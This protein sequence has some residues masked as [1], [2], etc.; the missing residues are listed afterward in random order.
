MLLKICLFFF[1]ISNHILETK[2]AETLLS[3]IL[4]NDFLKREEGT[5]LANAF[6]R[7]NIDIIRSCL[8]LA[9]L[10][11]ALTTNRNLTSQNLVQISM[12]VTGRTLADYLRECST[13]TTLD[14][15]SNKFQIGWRKD[16]L[17]SLYL[18]NNRFYDGNT[19]AQD[20][21]GYFKQSVWF[22]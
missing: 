2:G 8:G 15:S 3:L 7:M 1:N 20:Y 10:L 17:T 14:L 21:F 9:S 13:L 12:A 22:I 4:S 19:L 5:I 18:A 16:L 11:N 6:M